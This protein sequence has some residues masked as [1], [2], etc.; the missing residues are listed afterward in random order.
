M[1][2]EPVGHSCA[3]AWCAQQVM[4]VSVWPY[5]SFTWQFKY[6]STQL[7]TSVFKVSPAEL[8]QRSDKRALA[9]SCVFS[10]TPLDFIM[11]KAVGEEAKLVILWRTIKSRVLA[12][13]KPASL[14]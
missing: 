13:S 3:N 6:V 10:N 4:P 8:A 2:I 9:S 1:P 12:A 7:T 11:R 5:W 14:K